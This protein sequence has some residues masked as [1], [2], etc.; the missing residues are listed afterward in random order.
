M[1]FHDYAWNI[2]VWYILQP[3]ELLITFFKEIQVYKAIHWIIV[4][5]PYLIIA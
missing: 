2:L 4:A 5:H 1:V 3:C